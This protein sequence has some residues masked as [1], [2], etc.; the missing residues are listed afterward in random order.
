MGSNFIPVDSKMSEFRNYDNIIRFLIKNKSDIEK[1][2]ELKN[3]FLPANFGEKS[4]S[5]NLQ[6]NF[7]LKY[8]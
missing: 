8:V 1:Y 5:Q 4:V 7:K 3:L 6:N 2:R